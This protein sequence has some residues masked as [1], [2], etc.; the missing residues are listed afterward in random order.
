MATQARGPESGWHARVETTDATPDDQVCLDRRLTWSRAR[1]QSSLISVLTRHLEDTVAPCPPTGP[2]ELTTLAEVFDRLPDPRRVRGRR[3]RLGSL[4]GLCLA[5]VLGGARSLAQIAR[6]AADATPEVHDQL[7]STG[8]PRTPPPSDACWHG[9][10]GTR[11][12][13]RW[14]P[15]RPAAPPTRSTNLTG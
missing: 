13:M 7:G 8:P 5:A 15:G 3:Y 2:Y 9:W 14:A 6:F 11:S 10:T 12:I 4:L 1:V